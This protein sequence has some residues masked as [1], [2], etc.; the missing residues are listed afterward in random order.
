M[1]K[2]KELTVKKEQEEPKSTG[3]NAH[4]C[5]AP[6]G[7][8][9]DGQHWYCNCHFGRAPYASMAITRWMQEDGKDIV[10]LSADIRKAMVGRI[11]FPWHYYKPILKQHYP[12]LMPKKTD[13]DEKGKIMP[14]K[15]LYKVDAYLTA[16]SKQIEDEYMKQ[17]NKKPRNLGFDGI[18][19]D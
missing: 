12:E 11:A 19:F 15:W 14:A 5:D 3:C 7:N 1:K 9:I 2:F 18:V 6:A 8:S 4:N 17:E 16:K 13:L 10:E